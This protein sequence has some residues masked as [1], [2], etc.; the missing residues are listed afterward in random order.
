MQVVVGC[1][2]QTMQDPKPQGFLLYDVEGFARLAHAIQ[3]PAN[4]NAR[5]LMDLVHNSLA[6]ALKGLI[7]P[8]KGR[9]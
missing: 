2:N 8:F 9:I 6:H 1:R 4:A 7:R 3:C 5:E